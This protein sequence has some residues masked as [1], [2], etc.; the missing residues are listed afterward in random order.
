MASSS[1]STPCAACK[2]LRRKCVPDCVF[3]PYFPPEE[4]QKFASVHKIFGAS[5]VSKILNEVPPDQREDAVNSLAYEAEARMKDP[6][7]GCVGAISVLQRQ[8]IRLQKELDATNADLFRYACA[9][10]P[11]AA[12]QFGRR[13]SAGNNGGGQFNPNYE[14]YYPNS[15]WSNEDTSGK[16]EGN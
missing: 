12:A 3:A 6:V 9:E 7:Y 1:Y 8:V 15:L 10:L 13:G 14:C 16:S 4:P 5:N 2:F 11:V